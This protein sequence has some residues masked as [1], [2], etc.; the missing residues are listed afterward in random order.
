[1][2][3]FETRSEESINLIM[4]SL[5]MVGFDVKRTKPGEKKRDLFQGRKWKSERNH[6]SRLS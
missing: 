2:K 6:R 1:M 4:E 5:R 3:K